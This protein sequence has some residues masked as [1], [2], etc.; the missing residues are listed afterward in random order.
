[1]VEAQRQKPVFMQTRIHNKVFFGQ[2]KV[3]AANMQNIENVPD[4]L[5]KGIV[6]D[7]GNYN[8]IN[9]NSILGVKMKQI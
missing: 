9:L 7:P 3:E 6:S 2:E 5:K 1:M 8:F 4:I